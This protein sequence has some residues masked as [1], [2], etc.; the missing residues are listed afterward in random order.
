[1]HGPTSR[2]KIARW[3]LEVTSNDAMLRRTG[4]LRMSKDGRSKESVVYTTDSR[5]SLAQFPIPR[6]ESRP[7]AETESPGGV[8]IHSA[9]SQCH[10]QKQ[11]KLFASGL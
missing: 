3:E 8:A 9:M 2:G 5:S 11:G 1:M 6:A 7:I 4:S 10:K